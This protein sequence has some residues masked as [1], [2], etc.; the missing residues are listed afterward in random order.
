MLQRAR[1]AAMPDQ[2]AAVPGMESR[3][4]AGRARAL[5]RYRVRAISFL[6]S[7]G[8]TDAWPLLRRIELA[9]ADDANAYD[10]VSIYLADARAAEIEVG[11]TYTLTCE[12]D[13]PGRPVTLAEESRP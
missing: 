10:S 6:P 5:G 7:P 3:P 12:L 9:G 4:R 11:A 2:E 13:Q 8:P 1:E